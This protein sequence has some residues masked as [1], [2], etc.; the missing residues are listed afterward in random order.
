MYFPCTDKRRSY[1]LNFSLTITT[2][3]SK[4]Y[5]HPLRKTLEKTFNNGNRYRTGSVE[6]PKGFEVIGG[7][8]GTTYDAGYCLVLYSKNP[9][10]D[11]IIS[12]VFKADGKHNLYLLMNQILSKY[13][14]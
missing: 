14:K 11:D 9:N 2:H 5:S 6:T 8:T 10:G 1:L 7:K 4:L 13:A 12:I 3:F